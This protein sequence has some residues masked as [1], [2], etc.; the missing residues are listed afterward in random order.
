MLVLAAVL[1]GCSIPNI[2]RAERAVADTIEF[3]IEEEK[4]LAN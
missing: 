4:T 3:A 2:F 1:T